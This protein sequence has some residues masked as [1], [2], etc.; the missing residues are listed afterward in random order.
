MLDTSGLLRW[1]A[2]GAMA[3]ALVANAHVLNAYAAD[4]IK[5]GVVTPLS[6]AYAP[7][8]KQVRWGAELAV[9]EINAAG[10]VKGRPFELLFEDE[11][12]NPPVAVRKSEKLLQQDKVDL[13]TGTVNSG[14]T[15]AV[16]QLA[17]RNDRILIT[18][19]SYAPTIT[20]A[21]C[22]PNVFRVNA[23]AF[24]QS[25]ALTA[26]LAKNVSGKRYFFIGPDYEMGRSTIGAFQDDIKRLG[27]TDVGST[28]PPLG[29]KDFTQYIGQ[30]RAARPDVIMTAT[31]G[32][33]TVR[34]L[35]QLKEYGILSDKLTLAGAAGAVTQENIGAMGGAG[36][37]FLSAAGYSTDID[38]SANK[39]FVAAFKK[40]F[41]SDP[42]LFGADTYG[43]FYLLKQAI[44]K[45]GG[46]DTAKL[47]AAMEDASW[48]TPQGSK[49]IRKGDHQA[50]VDMVV[51]KVKGNDFQ[52]V[53]KV[54]GEEAV[55]P[56]KC[57]RF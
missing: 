51:V 38:T 5:V 15:L 21:Q 10:G 19:V 45:A 39:R 8:G 47:R 32:N 48:E 36:D 7:I 29:A 25:N 55:G 18:T 44:E 27:G 17:E 33:D 34:L 14:S 56:D 40:E 41:Q 24:M 49:K 22:S 3:L 12:A 2:S 37:G 20:G 16:G 52:T 13:L 30:I 57:D 53:G 54:A 42:D 4:P 50:V 26:W 31:A 46:T 35:T 43:L 28:F 1:S 9:K 11:E 23:N 6:G